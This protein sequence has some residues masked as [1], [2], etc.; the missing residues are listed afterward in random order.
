MSAKVDI[1]VGLTGADSAA[2]GL[3][4]VANTAA[5]VQQRVNTVGL[6]ARREFMAGQ[7]LQGTLTADIARRE[8]LRLAEMSNGFKITTTSANRFSDEVTEVNQ[9]LASLGGRI[10]GI[11]P[12]LVRLGARFGVF[13]LAAAGGLAMVTAS[14]EK[15]RKS[16]IESGFSDMGTLGA[17]LNSVGLMAATPDY[18]ARDAAAN[19]RGSARA[20]SALGKVNW[21]DEFTKEVQAYERANIKLSAQQL[22]EMRDRHQQGA[23]ERERLGRDEKDRELRDAAEVEKSRAGTRAQ[24]FREYMDMVAAS[25]ND[26]RAKAM[27]PG[28][29]QAYFAGDYGRSGYM[30]MDYRRQV[31]QQKVAD[32]VAADAQ[33]KV[34]EQEEKKRGDRTAA[35][36]PWMAEMQTPRGFASTTL[37]NSIEGVRAVNLAATM[38]ER[39]D[40][41]Q[42]ALAEQIRLLEDI[43]N[44]TGNQTQ[45]TT[46]GAL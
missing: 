14:A 29:E 42:R 38:G 9:G 30:A 13:G 36:Q 32:K 44:N 16:L 26:P 23:E 22:T 5:A 10:L 17:F 21:Q 7:R 28:M 18:A 31:E 33:R 41:T 34:A 3:N 43:R 46:V 19:E 11:D 40:A 12:I 6:S 2:A 39:T 45:T 27:L 4:R 20:A 25:A 37:S 8:S 1:V 24:A 15:L 35:L